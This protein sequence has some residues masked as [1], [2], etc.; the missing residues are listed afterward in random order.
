MTEPLEMEREFP[1]R[2]WPA[3]SYYFDNMSKM[4]NNLTNYLKLW[5]ANYET[6]RYDMSIDDVRSTQDPYIIQD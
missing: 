3:N 5:G 6:N 1:Y 4:Q 2:P